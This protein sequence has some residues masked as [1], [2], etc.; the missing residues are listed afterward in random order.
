MS[1]T[2][3]YGPEVCDEEDAEDDALCRDCHGSGHGSGSG[4][5]DGHWYGDGYGDGD[6]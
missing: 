4:S 5:G 6:G 2:D 1:P 3:L